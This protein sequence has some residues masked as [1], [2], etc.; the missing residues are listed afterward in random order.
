MNGC[1]NRKDLIY[2]VYQEG[3]ISRAAQKLFISQPS[4]SIMIRKIEDEVGVPLFDR[5]TKPIQLTQAGEEY[6]KATQSI[7][8]IEKEFEHFV[9]AY[10]QLMTGSLTIG[11]NQLLSSLVLPAYISEFIRRYP[12]IRLHLVD[13]NSTVLENRIAAGQ[14]DLVIDNLAMDDT[15]FEQ[16]LLREEH[17]MLAVPQCFVHDPKLLACG[18]TQEEIISGVHLER[19]PAVLPLQ[20]LEGVPFISMT[21]D[22]DTR[23]RADDILRELGLAPKTILEIDRLVTLYNFVEMGTAASIVSDTL[24]QNIRHRSGKVL[25]YMLPSAKARRKIYVSY[26]RNRYYSKAMQAF[27]DIL[28][29]RS[30]QP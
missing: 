28:F 22:N 16:K 1:F 26:K 6:I 17:L 13:D 15:V 21:K 8:S 11:A 18:L 4:L 3:S 24:V 23:G 14:L 29:D 19:R 30:I 27:M 9:S 5:T 12:N 10:G 2:T 25:F 20:A 7:L